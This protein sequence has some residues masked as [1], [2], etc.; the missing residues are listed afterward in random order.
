MVGFAAL[1]KSRIV[2]YWLA[3][4]CIGWLDCI[5]YLD[6]AESGS[7]R[8]DWLDWIGL[9]GLDHNCWMMTHIL[10]KDGIEGTDGTDGTDGLYGALVGLG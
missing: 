3:G 7:Y 2:L 9:I 4:L 10:C 8:L 1:L 6:I 5:V